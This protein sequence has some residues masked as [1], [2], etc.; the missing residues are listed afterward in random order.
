MSWILK[1]ELSDGNKKYFC[2]DDPSVQAVQSPYDYAGLYDGEIFFADGAPRSDVPEIFPPVSY[3][4]PL[5]DR[6][7]PTEIMVRCRE[8]MPVQDATVKDGAVILDFG[9]N[10]AGIIEIDPAKM[11]GSSIRI[12]HG[13]ILDQDGNLYTRN[14]RKAKAELIYHRGTDTAKY[15]P[16]FTYMGFRY[17]EITGTDYVPD[18]SPRMPST[19][20]WSAPDILHV[21]ILSQDRLYQNQVWGQK[22]N[23]IEVPTDCPQRDERMG[24]PETGRSSL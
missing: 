1:A 20:T 11:T 17:A 19:A 7:S 14:L 16:R 18:S 2:S 15:R 13:E 9:Q 23:Y 12:R 8:E 22:S 10:F 24:Y 4:G 5:P 21:T 6:F 3:E